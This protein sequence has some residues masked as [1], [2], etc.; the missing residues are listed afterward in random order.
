[1]IDREIEI[2][3]GVFFSGH[4][5]HFKLL[6]KSAAEEIISWDYDEIKSNPQEWFNSLKIVALAMQHGP[7]IAYRRVKEVRAEKDTPI[8]TLLCNICNTKFRVAPGHPYVFTAKLNGKSFCDYQCSEACNKIRRQ[9]VYTE[10]LGEVVVNF[11]KVVR[12]DKK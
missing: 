3:P 4:K 7:T 1:M 5:G 9:K 10:E 11:P 12:R 8:G 2:A 6:I